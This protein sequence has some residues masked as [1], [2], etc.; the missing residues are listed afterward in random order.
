MRDKTR[1]SAEQRLLLALLARRVEPQEEAETLSLLHQVDWAAFLKATPEDLYPCV[2]FGLEPYRSLIE[3]RPEWER[4]FNAR[5]ST[6]V[7]NLLLRHQL[8]RV[9][10]ALKEI[11]IRALAL[12]GIVLAYSVYPDL[13][14]RPMSDLDVLVPAGRRDEAVRKLQDLDFAYAEA[15]RNVN[16]NHNPRLVPGQEW[17]L[18]LRLRAS[19]VLIE[20]HSQL[21]CS[22]PLFQISIGE[23]WSRSIVADLKGLRVE[24]LCPEDFLF[25]VCLHLSRSHRFEKGLLPFVDLKYLLESRQDWNW[26]DIAERTQRSG[27]ATW[28]YLTLDAARDLVGAPV[29]DSFFQALPRPDETT[30]LRGLLDKQIWSAECGSSVPFLLPFLLAQPSW[31]SRA[32][33]ILNRARL[34]DKSELDSERSF[35]NLVRFTKLYLRR[36]LATARDKTSFYAK[37]WKTGNLKFHTLRQRAALLRSSNALLEL[38]ES[39]TKHAGNDYFTSGTVNEQRPTAPSE[40]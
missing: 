29:P 8:G 20:I 18:P 11:G 34:V 25:H 28:M 19:T 9:L 5:R 35:V 12:K 7:Q 39:E 40:P 36:L 27:C 22:E 16:R 33:T 26:D 23:F 3:S 14:L 30:Q 1:L 15:T 38:I 10:Q 2:A 4:F 37:A 21:E 24:T 13:S 31:R 17:A 32:R 6:A